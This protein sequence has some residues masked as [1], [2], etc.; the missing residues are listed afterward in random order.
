MYFSGLILEHL[1][2]RF[3]Y[4]SCIGFLRYHAEKKQ[5]DTRTNGGK[6]NLPPQLPLA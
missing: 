2:V 3:G 4:P 6:K 5:T 1:C